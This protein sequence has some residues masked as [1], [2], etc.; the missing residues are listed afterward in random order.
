MFQLSFGA[1]HA[2]SFM[3]KKKTTKLEIAKWVCWATENSVCSS[4]TFQMFLL[5]LL[6]W[7][8]YLTKSSVYWTMRPWNSQPFESRFTLKCIEIWHRKEF[9]RSKIWCQITIL[10]ITMLLKR[11][12]LVCVLYLSGLSIDNL[13]PET[14]GY[15]SEV[16]IINRDNEIR[17]QCMPE[18]T[19]ALYHNTI[20]FM[21]CN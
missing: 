6:K 16:C 14:D 5:S 20:D 2:F 19:T 9:N 17:F 21:F 12:I 3:M 10:F 1:I 18:Y 15:H 11:A 4:V 7:K 13:N 8:K